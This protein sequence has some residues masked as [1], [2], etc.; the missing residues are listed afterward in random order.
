MTAISASIPWENY[1]HAASDFGY[2]QNRKTN[3]INFFS[4]SKT[5]PPPISIDFSVSTKEVCELAIEEWDS[6][7]GPWSRHAEA[8]GLTQESCRLFLK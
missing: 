8:R 2:M 4:L 1:S 3:P 7:P 6:N 5:E